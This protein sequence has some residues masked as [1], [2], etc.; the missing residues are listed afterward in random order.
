MYSVMV[1][2]YTC[3][4]L[5]LHILW[6]RIMC[7]MVWYYVCYGLV[8]CVLWFGIM[9]VMVWYYGIT[10]LWFGISKE[11]YLTV[12]DTRGFPNIPA[13][14]RSVRCCIRISWC[15]SFSNTRTSL[16]VHS[17]SQLFLLSVSRR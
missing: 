8:L 17:L 3:Y 12:G 5:E 9:C 2:Y 11:V 7:V 16:D 10:V 14:K 13:N 6:F 1:G 15:S 4:S